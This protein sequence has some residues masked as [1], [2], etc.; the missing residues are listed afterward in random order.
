VY[1]RSRMYSTSTGRFLSR[2]TWGGDE[3]HPMSYNAWL[4][5][6]SNP[7][8][9][10]DPT[11]HF[12]ESQIFS[13]LNANT[14]NDVYGLFAENG[15]Y[16]GMWGIL[17]ILRMTNEGDRL[18]AYL[19]SHTVT[20][21]N[22]S[23]IP[24]FEIIDDLEPLG[25]ARYVDGKFYLEKN[26]VMS[27]GLSILSNSK[28]KNADHLLLE[29]DVHLLNTTS[30]TYVYIYLSS[31]MMTKRYDSDKLDKTNISLDIVGLLLSIFGVA[32]PAKAVRAAR[33]IQASSYI[34]GTVNAGYSLKVYRDWGG[35]GLSLV[36]AAP[37]PIVSIPASIGSLFRD[38]LPGVQP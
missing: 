8:R 29:E 38:T 9:Y 7:T 10:T 17:D 22:P 24:Q 6:Y 21:N 1:L 27:N 13:I 33:C 18:T 31:T 35:A 19:G 32:A 25:I 16:Q 26:G 5:S 3:N 20:L 28:Y 4:Y 12:S 11:G 36:G 15:I 14:W 23:A 30:Y 37:F 34:V 2:D